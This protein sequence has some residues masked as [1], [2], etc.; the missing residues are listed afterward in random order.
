MAAW[1][2]GD[3]EEHAASA[4]PVLIEILKREPK[5]DLSPSQK[6]KWNE[7]RG[8][9]ALAIGQMGIEPESTITLLVEMLKNPDSEIWTFS[10]LGIAYFIVKTNQTDPLIIKK[11]VPALI[12]QLENKNYVSLFSGS[13]SARPDH[14][15]VDALSRIG[16]PAIPF[17]VDALHSNEK[18]VKLLAIE[19]I[20]WMPK[21]KIVLETLIKVATEDETADVR[22][23][24]IKG[25][26]VPQYNSTKYDT[27][28]YSALIKLIKDRDPKVREE[29]THTIGT[30]VSSE[31]DV[32]NP[33][34][35][36]LNDSN[37]KV[38]L[39]A[40]EALISHSPKKEIKNNI[41]LLLKD[42]NEQVREKAKKLL[43]QLKSESP[44]ANVGVGPQNPDAPK[45]EFQ[46]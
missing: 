44:P 21:R 42:K 23:M 3:M 45:N 35:E 37:D 8:A 15:A 10:A 19:S 13:G 43:E 9:A 39:A 34:I 16:E 29:A 38:R 5:A 25:L 32:T 17:L 30:I 26:Q 11:A 6:K 20:C 36:L 18:Q 22:C 24:A 14:P 28:I 4:R 46:K 1:A 40:I 12:E 2:L 31:V 27:L 41:E 33:L 7:V